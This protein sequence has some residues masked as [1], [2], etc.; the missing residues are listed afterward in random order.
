MKVFLFQSLN[1]QPSTLNLRRLFRS[2]ALPINAIALLLTSCANPACPGGVI[3]AGKSVKVTLP[4]GGAAYVTNI[5]LGAIADETTYNKVSAKVA[6]LTQLMSLCCEK[7]LA[8]QRAHDQSGA[9]YWSA[10]EQRCFEQ[11]L[12]LE[13]AV[14][15][16]SR[17][18]AVA[19]GGLDRRSVPGLQPSTF[20]VQPSS[21]PA[22][23]RSWLR[24][25]DAVARAIPH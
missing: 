2:V 3:V 10:A 9:A 25:T 4:S 11:F 8:A 12:A 16:K 22:A 5:N 24:R 14:K 7:K 13:A 21:N 6:D 1:S 23:L 18:T 20:T 19:A 17:S 15:P